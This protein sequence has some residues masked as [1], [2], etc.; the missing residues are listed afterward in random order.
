MTFFRFGI[1]ARPFLLLALALLVP[2]AADADERVKVFILAGQSNMQGHGKV[3]AEPKANDGQ[4]SLEWLVKNPGTAARFK[5]LVDADGQWTVREDVRI[6]YLGR[7]GN[8]APGFG[9]REGYI[10]PELGFGQVVGDAFEEP[11]LL[12]KLA[13]GGKSL[14]KDF[15]PPSSGGE[16]G[17]YYRQLIELTKQVLGDAKSL[18]PQDADRKLELV[19]FGWHQGWNDRVNQSFNDQYEQNLANFIR[20]IRKDLGV[21][22]L[23]VVIAETG[24][25]GR[26]EKHPRAL[27]LMK[28]QAAVAQHD[29]FQ[30]NVAF[31]GTRDFFRP[32]E[33]SPSGQAYHWNSNAETYYLI[34]EG[35]GK[36]MVELI[37]QSSE[38]ADETCYIYAPSR[39]TGK[40]LIVQ[41]SRSDAGLSLK[42]SRQIDLE[43]P[44]ATIAAHPEKPLLYVVAPSGKEGQTPGAVVTLDRTGGYVQ[45]VPVTFDHGYSYL[46]LDR[47]NRF[48]LG[49]NYGD[50]FVDVYALDEAGM[51]GER[52]AALD[53][54]RRNAHSVLPSPDNRFVYIPYVKETNAIF[55]YRFDPES[56]G[57]T[58]LDPKNAN[59]PDDTGPRHMAYHPSK[60]IVYFSNEQHLGV[61]AYDME[62]SGALKLR[63]V[64]D[65][66]GKDEP[67]QGVSSSDIVI[68]PDG[69]FLYAGIRGH[70]RD[71]DWIARYRVKDNGNVEPL[72]L[73]PADKI[74]WGL[75]LSAH[76][77]YLFATAFQDGTLTAFRIDHDG[78]LSRVGSLSWDKNVSD[79]VTR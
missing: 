12:I 27:S 70:Q 8:L 51:P 31:V 19:G 45:H 2:A 10:G 58:A 52:V 22:K 3:T 62:K 29:E 79:L 63:Q 59:P 48:L 26:E 66:V 54:G 44:A 46:S 30:G 6:W 61:S 78:S 76:A 21:P 69:R 18:F 49:A 13:W 39:S 64:C 55:Q 38:P 16:V 32:K 28:A 75:A 67:K 77:R 56:G 33:K 15:R 43:F 23:P 41:A 40:L 68:T 20:D 34:G 24:M 57:L 25:S 35:M 4:G 11:V 36:A 37:R 42:L 50:G 17:P 53:E 9:A 73:T 14:A 74:P 7:K 65:A 60:P 72:G 1:M 71:F 47:A 5:H